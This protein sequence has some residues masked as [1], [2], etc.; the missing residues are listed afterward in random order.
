MPPKLAPKY[1]IAADFAMSGSADRRSFTS[2]ATHEEEEGAAESVKLYNYPEGLC[3]V[4]WLEEYNKVYREY[5]HMTEGR[6]DAVWK[7]KRANRKKEIDPALSKIII[8]VM[9]GQ[10]HPSKAC[11]PFIKAAL[12]QFRCSIRMKGAALR[13]LSARVSELEKDTLVVRNSVMKL[14]WVFLLEE[15]FEEDEEEWVDE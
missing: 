13:D 7:P 10:G 9:K 6:F 8:Q 4:A 3:G 5:A 11:I 1:D 14:L 12:A 2:A 15:S